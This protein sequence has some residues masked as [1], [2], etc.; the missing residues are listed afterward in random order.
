MS[1]KMCKLVKED[2]LEDHLTEYIDIVKKPKYVCK[3]CGRVADE[4]DRLCKP[5]KLKD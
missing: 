1:K 5:K 2:Y 3:K 4:E